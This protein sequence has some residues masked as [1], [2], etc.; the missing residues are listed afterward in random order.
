[1]I[2]RTPATADQDEGSCPLWC[3]ADHAVQ[4]HDDDRWHE[5][6]AVA[7]AVVELRTVRVGDAYTHVTIA[8]ELDV[9]LQQRVGQSE[10]FVLFGSGEERERNFLLSVESVRRLVRA[11]DAIARLPEQAE[12]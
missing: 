5:S 9:A 1:M 12:A 6:A 3:V 7:V 4:H 11:L 10:P 2:T 8:G